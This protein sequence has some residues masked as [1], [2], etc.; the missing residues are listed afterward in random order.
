MKTHTCKKIVFDYKKAC[1]ATHLKQ[2]VEHHHI[3]ILPNFKLIQNLKSPHFFPSNL[4]LSLLEYIVF[5]MA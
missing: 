1:R 5:Y 4:I 3:S 2:T